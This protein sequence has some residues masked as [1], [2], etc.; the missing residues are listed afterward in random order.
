MP[1]VVMPIERLKYQTI[2]NIKELQEFLFKKSQNS[3]YTRIARNRYIY[4]IGELLSAIDLIEG[5]REE[6]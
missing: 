5:I 6:E 2:S 4:E 3:K 1:T